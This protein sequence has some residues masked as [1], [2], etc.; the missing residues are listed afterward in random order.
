MDLVDE[1]D[2]GRLQVGQDCGEVA[3]ALEGRAGGAPKTGSHLVPE[4]VGD[5]RLSQPRRSIDQHV[6]ERLAAGQGG[7]DEDRQVGLHFFLADVFREGARPQAQ[8]DPTVVALKQ[9]I[10]ETVVRRGGAHAFGRRDGGRPPC[11]CLRPFARLASA[12]LHVWSV[13]ALLLLQPASSSNPGGVSAPG[14]S[15]TRRSA[16]QH[17]KRLAQESLERRRRRTRTPYDAHRCVGGGAAIVAE[18][19][20]GEKERK[21]RVFRFGQLPG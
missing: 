4:D 7:L 11:R 3:G 14:L 5:R 1:Q 9:R 17:A 20:Q 21:E 8:V 12:P 15:A 19:H 6:V 16:G 10:E 18:V 2:G 13:A